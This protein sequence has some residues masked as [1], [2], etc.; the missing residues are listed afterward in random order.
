MNLR[1][2]GYEPVKWGFSWVLL[3][4][5]DLYKWC[6]YNDFKL[7]WVYFHCRAFL[8]EVTLWLHQVTPEGGFFMSIYVRCPFCK[9]DQ[10]LRNKEC[11]KCGR[12]IPKQ[13]RTYRVIVKYNGKVVTKVVPSSLELAKEIE[14]KIKVELISGEYYD[15]RQKIPT[16]NEVWEK[17]INI[18]KV[19]GKSWQKDKNRYDRHIRSTLGKKTMDK[20]TTIDIQKLIVTMG[21]QT[22]SRGKPYS[23]KTIRNTVEIVSRLFNFAYNQGIFRCE[24]PCKGAKLPKVDNEVVNALTTEQVKKLVKTLNNYEDKETANL[25]KLLL[26]T[27]IRRGEAFKLTWSDIDFKG[28][29]LYLRNPKGGKSQTIPLNNTAIKTLEDQLQ[30]KRDG[31]DLVFPSNKNTVRHD[32]KRQW[33]K[34]KKLAGIPDNF[35]LHDLRHTFASL[36][37]S[38]GKVDIYTLQ[39]L[40]THKSPQMTQRY[41]HLIEKT[42]RDGV[43]VFDKL[44]MDSD[45]D[46]KIV[47]VKFGRES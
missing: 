42:L 27:G 17:Y 2:S 14:T 18:Q 1:P 32:I 37:A 12:V 43:S 8:T 16:L 38:S 26:F 21:K 46:E 45:I 3:F 30:Y 28:G 15:R 4:L 20:I 47:K 24:N 35:R 34:I 44:V 39:K 10:K 41:A 22:T 31:V 9:S 11:T 25:V 13:N 33:A 6:Q 36:L 7:T 40:L 5:L 29:W 23:P 19:E